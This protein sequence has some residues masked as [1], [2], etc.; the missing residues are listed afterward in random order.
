ML[1]THN[2]TR[3]NK[4]EHNTTQLKRYY[5]SKN[6]AQGKTISSNNSNIMEK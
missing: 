4:T 6:R 3:K 5:D 1:T 2:G